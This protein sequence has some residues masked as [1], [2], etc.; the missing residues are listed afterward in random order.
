MSD[1]ATIEDVIALFRALTPDEKAKAESLLPIVSSR[2]RQEAKHVGKNLDNMIANDED[3][4]LKLIAKQVEVGIVGRMIRESTEDIPSTQI[5]ESAGG[6]SQSYK[7]V[8]Q[9]DLWIKKSELAQ[10]GLRRQ[11]IS[12]LEIL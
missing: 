8:S 4:N 5:T 7:P 9:G 12:N 1:F 3:G 2:L 11:T 6:Y 10:L